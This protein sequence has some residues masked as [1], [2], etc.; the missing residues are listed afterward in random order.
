MLCQNG[1]IV[2]S[3]HRGSGVGEKEGSN[4][5]CVESDLRVNSLV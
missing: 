2:G 4:A 5:Q 1:D 3:D